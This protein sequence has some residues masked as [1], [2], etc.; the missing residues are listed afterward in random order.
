VVEKR[1]LLSSEKA[2]NS[3]PTTATE[4]GLKK[5]PNN[6]FSCQHH[7][8]FQ[9]MPN[10][11]FSCQT[12]LK[13]AKFLEFGFKNANLASTSLVSTRRSAFHASIASF[14]V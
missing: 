10:T 6:V 1:G 3:K 12:T 5:M 13:K 4:P 14:F 11:I 9:K 7:Q 8:K 2:L